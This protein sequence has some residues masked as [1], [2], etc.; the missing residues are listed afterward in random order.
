MKNKLLFGFLVLIITA[1]AHA[2]FANVTFWKRREPK[3][4]FTTAPQSVSR[5][6]CSSV[7]TVQAVNASS[8]AVNQASP[9][10]VSLSAPGLTFYTDAN[11]ST[12]VT[13]VTISA[14]SSSTSFYFVASGIGSS[15]LTA[16]AAP[17]KDAVQ[18]ET[19]ASNSFIWTGGG[20]NSNWNTGLNWSGGS[21]P[22][23]GSRVVFD[24]TCVSNCS[25]NMTVS[26]SVYA[27]R[28]LTG[29]TGTITQNASQ[30]LTVGDG[31]WFHQTGTF[32]GGNSTVTIYGPFTV[33]GGTYTSTSTTTNLGS[34]FKITGGTFSAGTT[35]TFSD[36]GSIS[37]GSA[38][39]NNVNFVPGN[40]S[41]YTLTGTLLINGNLSLTNNT[42]N[43][44]LAGGII[45][46]KGNLTITNSGMPGTTEIKV[47][48]SGTQTIDASAGNTNPN[49]PSL[50]IAATGTVN[51]VGNLNFLG[52]FKYVS[53]GTFNTGTA[54]L[55]FVMYSAAV[56]ADFGNQTFYNLTY[57]SNMTLTV[58]SDVTVTNSLTLAGTL[59]NAGVIQGPGKVTLLGDLILRNSGIG[60]S[61]DIQVHFRGNNSQ[62]VTVMTPGATSPGIIIDTTGTVNFPASFSFN[63]NFIYTAGT[64]TGLNTVFFEGLS[65]STKTINASGY[66]FAD[67]TFNGRNGN[68]YNIVGAMTMT[69]NLSFNSSA[70]SI[71]NGSI[72][73]GGNVAF[74]N[75]YRVW[76]NITFNGTGI[77]TVSQVLYVNPDGDMI[78]NKAS[79][80][81]RLTTNMDWAICPFT[82]TS[83]T[84]DLN[85]NTLRV[86]SAALNGNTV[87]KNGGT[88]IVNGVTSG[89]GALYGGT[90][91]P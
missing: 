65:G 32:T 36:R 71:L 90:V 54:G 52:N 28:V 20:G 69:G 77:Q 44:T 7:V 88:F 14:G 31:G 82:I 47:T 4:R 78:I 30:T 18:T 70:N 25:P 85:G 27:V 10:T 74:T 13:S 34:H 3:L 63:E 80:S 5:L 26:T 38:A 50:T 75:F 16:S 86:E 49:L 91:A 11:C 48:G 45:D 53:A 59:S 23:A 61:G 46:L 84:M 29:Y 19:S 67:V 40:G 6:N 12:E 66:T 8:V 83:G 39:F 15:D 81:V 37:V 64:I 68:T 60:G 87:T 41:T 1:S 89:N 79:G 76:A 35:Y 2:Q 43:V 56:T 9:L 24:G 57:W 58:L 17:Y 22:G 21:A 72:V 42:N 73:V 51:L 33:A 62:T 55:S